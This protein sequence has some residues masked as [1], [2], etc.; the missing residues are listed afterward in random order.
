[1]YLRFLLQ[2]IPRLLVHAAVG[3]TV[4][5]G[6]IEG[7]GE[8]LAVALL[9]LVVAFSVRLGVLR[10]EQIPSHWREGVPYTS[11]GEFVRRQLPASAVVITVQH[12]GSIRYYADRLTLR[13]DYLDP[14]WFPRAA[15][16]LSAS[17]YRPYVLLASFE[18]DAFRSRFGLSAADDAPGKP[19]ATFPGSEVN[20]LY[21]PL[22]RDSAIPAVI[23]TTV[24]YPCACLQPDRTPE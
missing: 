1:M 19:I 21:D 7:A 9:V 17:G 15:E 5:V 22:R 20:R 10:H 3:L 4:L 23:P 12:S 24:T 2:V 8:R 11:V 13:W 16:V 18:E 6:R 14:E